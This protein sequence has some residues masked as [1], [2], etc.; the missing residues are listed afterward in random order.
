MTKRLSVYLAGPAVFR[1][2]ADD[3]GARLKQLCDAKGLEPLWPLDNKAD[4]SDAAGLA[5]EIRRMNCAMIDRAAAVIADISPFRGPN[6]DPG[7]AFEIGY[8]VALN[9][10]VFLY[11]DALV[12]LLDR[13]VAVFDASR[14]GATHY[15]KDDM[16]VEDFGLVENLMI[17][18]A[19]ETVHR[20]FEEALE[21]FVRS[22]R[23]SD[24]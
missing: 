6:M 7:T 15:D 20:S 5:L 16:A 22:G 17:A 1:R 10:P 13:T 4:A 19:A 14:S 23:A 8:A 11:T 9:K 21:A 24:R 2:D 3:H 12:T 18:T